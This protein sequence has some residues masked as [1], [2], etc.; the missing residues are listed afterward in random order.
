MPR[1][2]RVKSLQQQARKLATETSRSIC[3]SALVNDHPAT[4]P[5]GAGRMASALFQ[6]LIER[7]RQPDAGAAEL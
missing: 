5:I 1:S 3:S 4:L 6:R 2:T 7:V